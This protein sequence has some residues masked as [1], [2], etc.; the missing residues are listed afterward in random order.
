[1]P[2]EALVVQGG[3]GVADSFDFH[4]AEAAAAKGVETVIVA[5]RGDI[6]LQAL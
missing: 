4:H 1:M 5:K 6:L 3:D 2:S